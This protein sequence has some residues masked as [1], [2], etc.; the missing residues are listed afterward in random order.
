[1]VDP[2][3]ANETQSKI[4][5]IRQPC[6]KDHL[7]FNDEICRFLERP[8]NSGQCANKTF[9]TYRNDINPVLQRG[10]PVCGLVAIAMAHQILNNTSD[11]DPMD[12]LE[13]AKQ[14]GF[15]K[16]GEILSAEFMLQL[17]M[18]VLQ[19]KGS[20]NDSSELTLKLLIDAI[21][22]RK[23]IL[24]PYD[25][26]KD[27]TPYLANG[28]QAHWCI[29][30]GVV[31]ETSDSESSNIAELSRHC[32]VGVTSSGSYFL[33]QQH[34]ANAET[35]A[36]L[37]KITVDRVFVV[38]RQGKSR[39]LGFWGLDTLCMSNGNL[40][41]LGPHRNPE[42]FIVPAEGLSECLQSKF[43]ILEELQSSV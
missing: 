27:H 16:Q 15:S 18:K 42:D 35:I 36:L 39:H 38:A 41:E 28:H 34:S 43:V 23:V 10:L 22:S 17:S 26:D 14:D 6:T 21:S 29:L 13:T 30:V 1:M 40:K 4:F 32:D 33:L 11:I 25:S 5:P 3:R 19:C 8:S 12:I 9:I 20:V 2:L 31:I 37:E 24:V 7:C